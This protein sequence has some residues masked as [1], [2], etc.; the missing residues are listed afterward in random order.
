MRSVH[1]NTNSRPVNVGRHIS[2]SPHPSDGGGVAPTANNQGRTN[3]RIKHPHLTG[4]HCCIVWHAVE[5][6]TRP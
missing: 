5:S 2:Q 1:V 6:L 3:E 4:M